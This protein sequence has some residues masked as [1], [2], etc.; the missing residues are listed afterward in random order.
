MMLGFHEMYRLLFWFSDLAVFRH[1]FA[2][3][4]G[5]RMRHTFFLLRDTRLYGENHPHKTNMI[6]AIFVLSS[7]H[8]VLSRTAE[9][10]TA[11]DF[12]PCGTNFH[13]CVHDMIFWEL[14]IAELPECIAT[15]K[16][17]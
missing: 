14:Q 9:K 15:G 3:G 5:L 13:D 8:P 6:S 17:E 4:L 10:K 1:T 12:L 7:F 11:T 2:N 16:M